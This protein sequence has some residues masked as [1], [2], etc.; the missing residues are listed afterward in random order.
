MTQ[1]GNITTMP[2]DHK[3]RH[4][5]IIEQGPDPRAYAPAETTED[6]DATQL[7][8]RRMLATWQNLEAYGFTPNCRKCS[9]HRQGLHARAWHCRHNEV[10]RSRIYQEIRAKMKTVDPE[11]ERR[12]KVRKKPAVHPNVDLPT[13]ET[14]RGHEKV[15][16]R[17]TAMEEVTL[18]SPDDH[19]NPD[20]TEDAGMN[21]DDIEDTTEFHREVDEAMDEDHDDT[22]M[23]ALMNLLHIVGVD[24]EDANRISGKAI[25]TA[26]GKTSPTFV[27][28]YGTRL[29]VEQANHVLRNLNVKGLAAFDYA[30][31]RRMVLQGTFPKL[32]TE[33]RHSNM[34]GRSELHGLLVLP[35]A[36]HLDAY[37]VLT[38]RKCTQILFRPY[39]M[40]GAAT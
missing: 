40:R 23:V 5:D 11:E 17:D 2:M 19:G 7:K 39:L 13:P 32:V 26:Q 15:E 6:D 36:R 18:G 35:R 14:P 12:L 27:E 29:I 30:L 22:E 3:T 28:A 37:K 34:S 4:L 20:V 8:R 1:L 38:S 9:L 10:C 24:A 21:G 16:H 33:R 31:A 25:R